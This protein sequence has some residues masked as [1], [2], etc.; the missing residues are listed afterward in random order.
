MEISSSSSKY[1][2]LLSTST[3]REVGVYKGMEPPKKGEEITKKT[4]V[5]SRWKPWTWARFQKQPKK[6][7]DLGLFQ[8]VADICRSLEHLPYSDTHPV[9]DIANKLVHEIEIREEDSSDVQR[10]L[11]ILF[12]KISEICAEFEEDLKEIPDAV[13][14]DTTRFD[15][16]LR[17]LLYKNY[18]SNLQKAIESGEFSGINLNH[19]TLINLTEAIIRGS[20][21]ERLVLSLKLFAASGDMMMNPPLLQESLYSLYEPEVETCRNILLGLPG[22]HKDHI[23]KLP[24][25]TKTYL[26]DVLE[27]NSKSRCIF[28]WSDPNFEGFHMPPETETKSVNELLG[29]RRKYFGD[30][31]RVAFKYVDAYRI[32]RDLFWT[33]KEEFD[34]NMKYGGVFFILTCIADYYIGIV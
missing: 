14:G 9:H 3:V 19:G 22:L 31:T 26:L 21:D 28:C 4:S 20:G 24:K 6:A 5:H 34:E 29:S 25:F 15:T 13:F 12:E 8:R 2:R 1:D 18:I 10:V 16:G 23:K 32:D 30:M 27:L 11:E 33:D 7:E 17:V